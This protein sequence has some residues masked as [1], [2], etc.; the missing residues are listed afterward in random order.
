MLTLN[1]AAA[2]ARAVASRSLSTS[3]QMTL[4]VPVQSTALAYPVLPPGA[5]S[6]V[7]S[8]VLQSLEQSLSTFSGHIRRIGQ[9]LGAVK[10]G[11]L[12]LLDEVGSGTD[13]S[14]GAALAMALLRHLTGTL[15][16]GQE[17]EGEGQGQGL[18]PAKLTL[19]TTHYAQLKALKVRRLTALCLA[20]CGK[21]A[22]NCVTKGQRSLLC[23]CQSCAQAS[24]TAQML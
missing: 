4:A 13:P 24:G 23:A 7:L 18:S 16:L 9:I 14:E 11:S 8:L 21:G 10:P 17:G 12:V 2:A 1:A 5:C 15:P 22:T 19:S 6:P 20:L 3:L